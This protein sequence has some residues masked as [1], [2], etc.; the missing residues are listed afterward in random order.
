MV[1]AGA[2]AAATR[3]GDG[4]A[5]AAHGSSC[6]G[7]P[8]ADHVDASGSAAAASQSDI[9]TAGGRDVC[10]TIDKDAVAVAARR[11]GDA[12]VAAGGKDIG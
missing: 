11:A 3:N 9:A 5:C 10:T 7:E 2:D 12:D 6:G 4:A 8:H 1:A